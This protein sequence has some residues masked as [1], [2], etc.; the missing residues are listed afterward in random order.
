MAASK[1]TLQPKPTTAP[2]QIPPM[3][4]KSSLPLPANHRRTRNPHDMAI[5]RNAAVALISDGAS[6]H[7]NRI[8]FCGWPH[9]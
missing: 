8:G 7:N 2:K 1:P 3:R 4:R 9:D 5:G 6:K